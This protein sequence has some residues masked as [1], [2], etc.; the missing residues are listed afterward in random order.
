MDL[1]SPGTVV[2]IIPTAVWILAMSARAGPVCPLM[3]GACAIGGHCV[4]AAFWVHSVVLSAAVA[5][6]HRPGTQCAD[7][8]CVARIVPGRAGAV[9]QVTL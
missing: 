8:M 7:I 1:I 3:P 6:V 5:L 2:I 9:V 4:A